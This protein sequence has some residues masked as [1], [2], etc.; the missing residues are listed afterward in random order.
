[1]HSSTVA[2]P[3]GEGAPPARTPLW[4][5]IFLISCSFL[6]K[7]GKFVCWRA[8]IRP[9]S[10]MRTARFGDRSRCQF[11]G[12]LSRGRFS[13]LGSLSCEGLCLGVSVQGRCLSGGISPGRS[14]SGGLSPGEVSVWG[15]LSGGL[16]PGSLYPGSPP[17]DRQTGVKHYLSATSL[18][19]VI[20]L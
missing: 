14:L 16:C 20:N 18:G 9:C 19:A 8:W 1:M 6:G 3:K 15:S 13:V 12:V 5:K 11:L 2:D 7:P 10:R 4:T 17:V